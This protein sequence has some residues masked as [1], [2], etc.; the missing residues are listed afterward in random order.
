MIGASTGDTSEAQV[1]WPVWRKIPTGRSWLK[2]GAP[3]HEISALQ[4]TVSLWGRRSGFGQFNRTAL[5]QESRRN[6]DCQRS[7]GVIH[8]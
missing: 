7:I 6:R 5:C 4:L 2:Q 8:F 1:E 3:L